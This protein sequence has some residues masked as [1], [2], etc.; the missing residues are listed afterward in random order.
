MKPANGANQ[1]GKTPSDVVARV[2]GGKA[3]EKLMDAKYND[4]LDSAAFRL[5]LI[6]AGFAV[7]L[8][9]G[10]GVLKYAL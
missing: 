2:Q 5:S 1:T 10:I 6:A 4:L 3:M 8:V 7:W 9:A